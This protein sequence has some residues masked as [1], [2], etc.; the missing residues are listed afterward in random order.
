MS[1]MMATALSLAI[2][3]VGF[4]VGWL[5]GGLATGLSSMAFMALPILIIG[6]LVGWL[7]EWIIDNQYR[8]MREPGQPASAAPISVPTAP[9]ALPPEIGELISAVRQV[10]LE[11]EHDIDQLEADI[12]SRDMSVKQLKAEFEAYVTSH[13]DDLTAIKGI[14]RVYQW[15]LRAVGIVSYKALAACTAG[16]LHQL[17]Q[18]KTWQKVD[19][20]SWIAQAQALI[21]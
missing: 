6:F 21:G 14:G 12:K 11:R 15:K 7:V 1:I 4:L 16:Q 5:V 2:L 3:I 20:E 10:S 13:P 17:L 9:P 19:L 8:R 18:I